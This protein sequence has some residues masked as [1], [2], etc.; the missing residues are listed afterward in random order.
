MLS[1]KAACFKSQQLNLR[2]G[3]CP[4][5][6]IVK[7]MANVVCQG[8]GHY[9]ECCAQKRIKSVQDQATETRLNLTWQIRFEQFTVIR[10]CFA[11]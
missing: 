1:S 8:R 2:Q 3:R 7:H 9:Q 11:Q 10:S 6:L 4:H 5:C